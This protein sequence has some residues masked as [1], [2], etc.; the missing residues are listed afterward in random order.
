MKKLL[1]LP[2]SGAHWLLCLFLSLMIRSIGL[3]RPR[4]DL[5]TAEL[6]DGVLYFLMLPLIIVIGTVEPYSSYYPSLHV[7]HF[8]PWLWAFNSL[9]WGIVVFYTG[10]W[11]YRR[12]RQWRRPA[13]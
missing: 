5:A 9:L 3:D 10:G 6:L 7:P 13:A 8:K 11:L 12:W 1:I 4:V 2:I